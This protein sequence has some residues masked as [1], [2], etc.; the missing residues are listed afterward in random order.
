MSEESAATT[1]ATTETT[2]ETT[3]E[4]APTT[5]LSAVS[6]EPLTL[7]EGEWL[8]TATQKGIGDKPEWMLDKHKTVEDQAKNYVELEKR[9]GAFTGTPKEGYKLNLPEG[10]EGDFDAQDPMLVAATEWATKSG[11][12]QQGFD[13]LITMYINGTIESPEAIEAARNAELIDV[14]GPNHAQEIQQVS[15]ILTNMMTPDQ[16]EAIKPLVNSPQAVKLVQL[17]NLASAPKVPPVSGGVNPEGVTKE[18]L[19]ELRAQ[20]YK[21]GPHKGERIWQVDPEFRKKV[22]AYSLALHGTD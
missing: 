2:T 15:G 7:G 10:V 4:A 17:M 20:R 1:E 19:N 3:T 8:Q 16:Y 18:G 22:D 5:L 11:V 21:D 14:L 13:E 12:S 6:D 9:F